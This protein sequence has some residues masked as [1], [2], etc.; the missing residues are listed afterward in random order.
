MKVL[1]LISDIVLAIVWW[2]FIY[3]FYSEINTPFLVMSFLFYLCIIINII[4]IIRSRPFDKEK[5]K[6][7][8]EIDEL[9][10]TKKEEEKSENSE[11]EW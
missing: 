7:K 2:W 4:Y 3:Y 6:L 9:K 10:N 1:I 5:E 11:I 8:K